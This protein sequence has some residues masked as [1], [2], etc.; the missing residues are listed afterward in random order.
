MKHDDSI[1]GSHAGC[2]VGLA[3]LA[4]KMELESSFWIVTQAH[5]TDCE[6][7]WC[8]PAHSFLWTGRTTVNALTQSIFEYRRREKRSTKRL[9]PA[10]AVKHVKKSRQKN[11]RHLRKIGFFADFCLGKEVWEGG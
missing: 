5:K 8:C 9:P 4:C 10:T 3:V 2:R 6:K 11:K 1:V 7:E